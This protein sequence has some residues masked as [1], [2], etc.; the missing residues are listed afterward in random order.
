MQKL[1]AGYQLREQR[2]LCAHAQVVIS[3]LDLTARGGATRHRHSLN[4]IHSMHNVAVVLEVIASRCVSTAG[5]VGE[6]YTSL[7]RHNIAVRTLK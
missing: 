4:S 2:R 3:D 1:H 6:L 7:F 5:R